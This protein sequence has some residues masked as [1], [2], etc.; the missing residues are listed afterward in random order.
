MLHGTKCL[1]HLNSKGSDI[2]AYLPQIDLKP[3]LKLNGLLI[4]KTDRKT[5]KI[6]GPLVKMYKPLISN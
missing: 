3:T 2:I 1:N 5:P 4:F 6:I